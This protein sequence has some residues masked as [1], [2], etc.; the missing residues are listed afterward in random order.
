VAVTLDPA[1]DTPEV[2]A[3]L[4]RMHGLAPPLY[5][6]VTGEPA[7]VERVLDQM[8]V[9]RQRDPQTG[10]IDHANVVMLLDRSGQVAYRFSVGERQQRWLASALQ[11]LLREPV[12][13]G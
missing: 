10:V 4:G 5:H 7:R 6:L 8:E 1:H 12:R 13:A 3:E 9:A 11:L 2:L